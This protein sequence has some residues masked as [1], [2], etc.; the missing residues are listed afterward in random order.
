MG[1]TP[2]FGSWFQR[3][4]SKLVGIH[5]LR[6]EVSQTV[7]VRRGGCVAGQAAHFKADRK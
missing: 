2:Y 1:R 7:R 5:C 6:P 4:H 3:S